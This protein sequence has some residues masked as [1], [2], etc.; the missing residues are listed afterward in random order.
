L[1]FRFT[2]IPGLEDEVLITSEVG[3]YLFLS[4][5]DFQDFVQYRLP[6][7]RPAYRDLLARHFMYEAGRDPHLEMIAA[8]Y[9]TPES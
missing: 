2:R 4:E 9:R 1:P 5:T 6:P 7:H 8:Q 3:E